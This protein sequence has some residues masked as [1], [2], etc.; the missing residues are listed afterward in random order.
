MRILH[1]MAI[2]RDHDVYLM[3]RRG[4]SEKDDVPGGRR[5]CRFFDRRVFGAR[6][7][8]REEATALRLLATNR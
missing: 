7:P 6:R 1:R 8:W 5:C 2:P 3:R 4:E